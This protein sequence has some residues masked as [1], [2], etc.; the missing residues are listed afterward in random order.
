M[1]VCLTTKQDIG[2]IDPC[3]NIEKLLRLRLINV[4]ILH[5]EKVGFHDKITNRTIDVNINFLHSYEEWGHHLYA[6][7]ALI[8]WMFNFYCSKYD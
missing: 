3:S 2:E 5:L 7:L 1:G 8:I 6:Y 4:G